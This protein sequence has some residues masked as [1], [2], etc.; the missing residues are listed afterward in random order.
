MNQMARINR[1]IAK[2]WNAQVWP[3]MER[4]A[5]ENHYVTP[6]PQR[7]RKETPAVTTYKT[8][9]TTLA[10]KSAAQIEAERQERI[11]QTRIANLVKAR[12]VKAQMSRQKETPMTEVETLRA[13]IA[14]LTAQI[15]RLSVVARPQGGVVEGA[16]ETASRDVVPVNVPS[17]TRQSRK[18]NAVN[19][20][21]PYVPTALKLTDH[22]H[23]RR[24]LKIDTTL[25]IVA[26][27]GATKVW[28][29]Q[30]GKV[31]GHGADRGEA[32]ALVNVALANAGLP[33]VRA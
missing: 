19:K 6:R 9:L 8:T 13:Q 25:V 28:D 4:E 15:E 12:A 27:N 24:S 20:K 23:G 1:Q 10:R 3:A 17:K 2:M 5:A 32:I 22:G 11:R 30:V 14:A 16:Y 31:K 21:A 18:E 33:P 7:Q 29:Y 26:W